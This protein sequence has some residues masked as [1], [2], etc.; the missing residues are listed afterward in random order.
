MRRRLSVILQQSGRALLVC[1]GAMEE[2]LVLCS[3]V[4]DGEELLPL[5]DRWACSLWKEGT[6]FVQ[7]GQQ[8]LKKLRE[9]G[10]VQGTSLLQHNSFP[11]LLLPGTA[12]SW[13]PWGSTSTWTAC[14]CWLWQ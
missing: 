14:E 5:E 9:G 3:R 13:P 4:Q 10:R 12:R 1:K 11:A 8:A 2:V 6:C 7:G